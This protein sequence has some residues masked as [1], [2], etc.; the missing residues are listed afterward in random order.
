MSVE[1]RH[2]R[3]RRSLHFDLLRAM[4]ADAEQLV[5]APHTRML[6]N[7]PLERLLAHLAL[8]MHS[9]IDGITDRGPWLARLVGPLLKRR[10]LARGMSP[11][12]RLPAPAEA[13]FFPTAASPREA[14]AALRLAAARTEREN[15][16]AAHPVLGRLG[17]DEWLRLHL[18]HAE[19][20]LSFALPG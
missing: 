4:L 5:A 6:G 10:I 11:G 7:W 8:A 15:M 14:L 17:H 3:G 20:H 1:T 9:S 13:R 18:R 2:V 16:G 12:F 19:M